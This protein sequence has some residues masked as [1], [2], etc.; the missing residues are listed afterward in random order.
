MPLHFYHVIYKGAFGGLLL[1]LTS[2]KNLFISFKNF[3]CPVCLRTGPGCNSFQTLHFCSNSSSIFQDEV[4]C[5]RSDYVCPPKCL[6]K[7]LRSLGG[8]AC[9]FFISRIIMH[10]RRGVARLPVN[11]TSFAAPGS[12][13]AWVENDTR[14]SLISTCPQPIIKSN[15]ESHLSKQK[16][17]TL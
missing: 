2:F 7:K 1:C 10:N 4:L 5:G 11:N 6:L 13:C 3:S 12:G 16:I 17:K 14:S 8:I 9:A 15:S